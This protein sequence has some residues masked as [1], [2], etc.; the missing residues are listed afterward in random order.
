MLAAIQ[1][2]LIESLVYPLMERFRGNRVRQYFAA[3]KKSESLSPDELRALQE[4]RLRDLLLSCVRH[5]PAY[6][7]CGLSEEA[8]TAG[9]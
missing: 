7:A 5:V 3:L 9:S 6:R 4:E 1:K 2:R 8:I